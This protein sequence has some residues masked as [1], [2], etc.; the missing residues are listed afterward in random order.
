VA[1]R[2]AATVVLLRDGSDGLEVWLQQRATTLVFAAGMHA[3]PGGAVDDE[4]RRASSLSFDP[5]AH[6]AVWRSSLE[7][8]AALAVA[9][10]RETEE[11]AGVVLPLLSLVPWSRWIT[12]PGPPRRFDA[13]FYVARMPDGQQARPRSSEVRAAEW[14]VVRSAVERHAAGDLPMWPPTIAT[15]AELV[16]HETVAAAL[17][18]AP[19]TIEAVTG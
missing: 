2:D 12:P 7:Q 19:R 6:A 18:A 16:P 5:G 3:F 11:E 13:R 9:A 1:I 14:V 8:A 17:V 10:V 4:D 15:L